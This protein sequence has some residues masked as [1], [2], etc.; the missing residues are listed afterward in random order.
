MR[1]VH[2]PFSQVAYNLSGAARLE[3]DFDETS[4]RGA[5][6]GIDMSSIVQG[7]RTSLPDIGFSA[8]IKGNQIVG[9]GVLG[10]FFGP[11]GNEIGGVYRNSETIAAFG[12]RKE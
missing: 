3:V 8:E 4:V 1:G 6:T 2:S 9:P 7:D 10:T 11:K 5:L 12:V